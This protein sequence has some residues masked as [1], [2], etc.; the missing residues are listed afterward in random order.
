MLR[1]SVVGNRKQNEIHQQVVTK[2]R[3]VYNNAATTHKLT[4]LVLYCFTWQADKKIAS[5]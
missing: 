1:S 3:N 4:N 5:N 2:Q